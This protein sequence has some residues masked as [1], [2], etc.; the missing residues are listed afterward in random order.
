MPDE[1]D[2]TLPP[3]DLSVLAGV[4]D[5]NQ[6]ELLKETM[7]SNAYKTAELVS[8]AEELEKENRRLQSSSL[9]LNAQSQRPRRPRKS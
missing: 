5:E 9:R 2:I 3:S 1:R 4:R 6:R 7:Q 8:R